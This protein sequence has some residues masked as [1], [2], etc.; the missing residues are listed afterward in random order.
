MSLV[1]PH[2]F[3]SV[4]KTLF[5]KIFK[6]KAKPVEAAPINKQKPYFMVTRASYE[7]KAGAVAI[8]RIESDFKIKELAYFPEQS[9]EFF[10]DLTQS[11]HERKS[12]II[13]TIC[14]PESLGLMKT[15]DGKGMI[16]RVKVLG[17]G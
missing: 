12:V 1:V 14:D 4:I 11:L 3:H 10:R 7:M 2:P 5:K 13:Q 17:G 6:A 9:S 8:I 15:P 16:S